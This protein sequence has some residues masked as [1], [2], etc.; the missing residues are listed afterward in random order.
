MDYETKD[1]VIQQEGERDRIMHDEKPSFK[2]YFKERIW[3]N[4]GYKNVLICEETGIAFR[5]NR[6]R[7]VR[8]LG[9]LVYFVIEVLL[10]WEYIASMKSYGDS[11]SATLFLKVTLVTCILPIVKKYLSPLRYR[12]SKFTIEDDIDVIEDI[13]LEKRI[14]KFPM[15]RSMLWDGGFLMVIVLILFLF[16]ETLGKYYDWHTKVLPEI[17]PIL[18]VIGI[19]FLAVIVVNVYLCINTNREQIDKT[20]ISVEQQ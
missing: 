12:W 4:K 11:D 9:A 7:I 14:T 18:V 6:N 16:N 15:E 13:K 10:V 1:N 19:V 8:L 5:E 20:D 2:S 3:N 17:M